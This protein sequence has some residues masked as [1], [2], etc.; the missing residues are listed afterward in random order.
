M[1]PVQE[2]TESTLGILVRA[3]GLPVDLMGARV[4]L[5]DRGALMAR[6]QMWLA[7][8]RYQELH[9]TQLAKG[10][11]SREKRGSGC[12]HAESTCSRQSQ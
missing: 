2:W 12:G 11:K 10:P 7:C 6:K 4:E 3:S 9:A 1:L 5:E 8:A